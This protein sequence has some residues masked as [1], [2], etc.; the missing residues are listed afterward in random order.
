MA[1]AKTSADQFAPAAPAAP[2]AS[3][4][5]ARRSV[6]P[7][8]V[9]IEQEARD[10]L[11]SLAEAFSGI[12][13][14]E[15]PEEDSAGKVTKDKGTPAPASKAREDKTQTAQED[16]DAPVLEGDDAN[17]DGPVLSEDDDDADEDEDAAADGAAGDEDEDTDEASPEG[18]A[19]ALEKRNFKLRE[20]KRELREQ[21]EAATKERD[22]LRKKLE[23]LESLPS[24]AAES[25]PFAEAKTE[26]E[27]AAKVSE[28]TRFAEWMD[29]L[30]D[31]RQEVYILK[32]A[33]GQEQEYDRKTIREWKK[34]AQASIAAAEPARK[35][36]QKAAEADAYARRKFPHVFNPKSKFNSV[37]LDLVEETPALN[38]LPNKAVLLGRMSVGKLVESG[39]FMLVP[40][41]K[42][43]AAA[44]AAAAPAPRAASPATLPARRVQDRERKPDL[45]ERALHNDQSA[46]LEHALGLIPD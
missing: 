14:A 17:E 5:P 43:K 41:G 29:D 12:G 40:K 31:D 16:D 18:K 46:L 45:M 6:A 8:N 19:K 39:E 33:S 44:K 9:Q 7:D 26:A 36:L 3:L 30:L 34:Q 37:V 38:K 42:V 27:I 2:V 20:Q 22:E 21:V 35:N 28:L 11:L 32:D 24:G 15:E 25:G 13:G 4:A 1:K 10:G 23:R